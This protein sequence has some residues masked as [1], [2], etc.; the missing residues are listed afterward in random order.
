MLKPNF[1]II[2]ASKAASTSLR[3]LLGRHP[4]IF[5]APGEPSFFNSDRNYRDLGWPWYSGLFAG[6]E[7]ARWRGEKSNRYTEKERF[8]GILARIRRDLPQETR[9]LYIVRD[10]V[11]RIESMW[12]QKRSHGAPTHHNFA[13]VVRQERHLYSQPCNYLRQLQPYLDHFP[14]RNFRVLFFEDFRRAPEREV[15]RVFR[16]LGLETAADVFAETTHLNPTGSRVGDTAALGRLRALPLYD[17]VRK[18]LPGSLRRSLKERWFRRPMPT[19]PEWP[20][21]L[22]SWLRDEL[23]ED[24]TTFLHAHGK[25]RDFWSLTRD[26]D[27]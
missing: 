18:A 4:E 7:G 15:E 1:L 22:L 23:A 10:P 19:R 8:P 20:P 26:A 16:F 3:V 24:T 17:R 25:P 9:F 6:S 14:R 13:R 11:T 27:G 5:C 2:G 12:L 21:E